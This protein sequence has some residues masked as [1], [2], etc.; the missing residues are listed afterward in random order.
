[1]ASC[2]AQAHSILRISRQVDFVGGYVLNN[3]NLDDVTASMKSTG[4][5][6]SPVFRKTPDN[7]DPSKI[8]EDGLEIEFEQEFLARQENQNPP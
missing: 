6:E 8:S 7:Q 4:C 5:Y 1:L 2:T 3:R